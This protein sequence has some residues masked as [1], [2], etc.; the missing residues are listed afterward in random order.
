[1]ADFYPEPTLFKGTNPEECE[2]LV[3]A[4]RRHALERGKQHDNEWIALFASTYLIGHAL[5]WY[6]DL[7]Q[8][9]QN[10]WSRLRPTLLARFGRRGAPTTVTSGWVRKWAIQT[11]TQSLA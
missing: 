9:I 2:V 8:S 5:H 10:D 11:A 6:E 1:M 7:D 3:A 4:I